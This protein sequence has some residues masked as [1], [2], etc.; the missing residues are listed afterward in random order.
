[1][2]L[3]RTTPRYMLHDETEKYRLEVKAEKH[4]I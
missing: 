2:K 4:A 3:D 1:M